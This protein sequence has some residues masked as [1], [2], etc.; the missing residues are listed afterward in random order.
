M[1]DRAEKGG[2]GERGGAPGAQPVRRMGSVGA[3]EPRRQPRHQRQQEE[4]EEEEESVLAL[5]EELM[6]YL[7]RTLLGD[8]EEVPKCSGVCTKW[9]CSFQ[10]CRITEGCM[11]TWAWTVWNQYI[12]I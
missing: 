2:M 12:R 9:M 7:G 3:A 4:E 8:R 10:L 11:S 5:N 1:R 6:M